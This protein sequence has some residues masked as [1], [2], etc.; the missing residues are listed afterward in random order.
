MKLA[1]GEFPINKDFNPE[2]EGW[3]KLNEPKNLW[4]F[5]LFAL[6]I[7]ITLALSIILF[8]NALASI[9]KYNEE[10]TFGIIEF[11][12]GICAFFIIL[13][14][15]HELIHALFA[16]GSILS[17]KVGIGVLPKKFLFYVYYQEEIGRNRFVLICLMP[18]ITL[19]LLPVFVMG[20]IG[21]VY[22]LAVLFATLNAFS[23]S[24]DIL[25]VILV[26]KQVPQKGIIKNKGLKSYWKRV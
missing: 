10:I 3:V 2:N 21:K 22:I 19:S 26:L 5:Q 18:F 24:G 1:I 8:S 25:G 13:I 15:L 17:D 7:G 9:H 16:P 11:I 12:I 6:P 23:S 14:P 4:L 20:L